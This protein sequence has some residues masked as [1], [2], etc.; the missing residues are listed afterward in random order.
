MGTRNKGEATNDEVARST[1]HSVRSGLSHRR[2]AA[3]SGV[4]MTQYELLQFHPDAGAMPTKFCPGH[5]TPFL[6]FVA[7]N[8]FCAIP[9]PQ[10]RRQVSP[11]ESHYPPGRAIVRTCPQA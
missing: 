2:A 3:E 7:R 9:Q 11:P 1:F 10:G 6:T 5:E 4:A 8:G